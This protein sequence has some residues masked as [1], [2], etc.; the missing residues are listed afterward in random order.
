MQAIARVNRV[1]KDKPGGLIVDYIGIAENLKQALAI[2]DSDVQKEAMLPLGEVIREMNELYGEVAL[3][4]SNIDFSGWRKKKGIELV[5]LFQSAMNEVISK[6][7]LLSDD[8]KMAYMGVVSKLSRLHALVM[9]GDEAMKIASD[10]QFFQSIREA[11]SKQTVMPHIIFPEET[12]S[13]IRSLVQG[14]VEAEGV[15][16]L[17]AKEGEERKSISIFDERF[18]E[19]I[20]KSKYQNLA[21]DTFRKM[22]DQEIK[23]RSRTNKARYETMLTLLADLI[24]KYENNVISSAEIIKHLLE[25][26]DE[27]KKL[28]QESKE[29]GLS[30]EEIVFYDTLAGDPD[31]KK[32]GIDIKEFVK[33]L[34]R[35]IRRD[36]AIDW[37][38]NETIKARIRQNVRL[39]LLQRGFVEQV[40]TERLIESIYQETV[41]V[42]REYLPV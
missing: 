25:I 27:I 9:P 28:D 12:E 21:I 26:A 17:F 14:A 20:K 5:E 29:L 36:L 16:D 18:A 31:L 37:T 10:I 8:R 22:L 42:Y 39:L 34:T 33:E 7:G 3:Y 35:R 30:S 19:E 13:A 23:V 6:D 1:Y 40:Q 15:I 2:Y 38:N 4:F 24:E 32:A 11:I 41:R